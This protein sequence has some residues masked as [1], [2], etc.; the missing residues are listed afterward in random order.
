[1]ETSNSRTELTTLLQTNFASLGYKLPSADELVS[2]DHNA[3]YHGYAFTLNQKRIIYRKA[4]VTPDRPDAFLALW[5]RPADCSNSK[6]IPFTNEFD[7]LLVAVSSDGLTS[8]NNQ[9][10]NS[11]SGLF[12]FP[13]ELLVKKGIVS[14]L[15]S[16]GKT[17]F[18]VFPPWSESRALKR[19]STF[20]NSAKVTQRWQCDYFLK[21]DQNKLIDLSKLNKILANAV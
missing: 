7:Y 17:A 11:Q 21:Q 19:T 8:S 9:V 12:I 20:S 1:M 6:P 3:Q 5:K 16:K 15:N 10:A 13:V 14:S 18:R 2:H 4:K